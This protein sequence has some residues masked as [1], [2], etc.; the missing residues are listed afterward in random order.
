MDKQPPKKNGGT[1]DSIEN[2]KP[3]STGH[4]SELGENPAPNNNKTGAQGEKGPAWTPPK[5]TAYCTIA[6]VIITTVY[7]CYAR[8]QSIQMQGAVT[9]A[10][11]QAVYMKLA[12]D[13]AADQARLE[14]RAWIGI[15]G[16]G[17]LCE[18]G[19]PMTL[20]VRFNNVGETPALLVT[21]STSWKSRDMGTVPDFTHGVPKESSKGV[22]ILP[23]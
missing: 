9:I 11:A 8:E 13:D 2:D 3:L 15:V 20:E 7:T 4:P 12:V 14:Q 21:N 6:I 23:P 10:A 19:K 16:M 17:F 18:P 1:T 22:I 5:I